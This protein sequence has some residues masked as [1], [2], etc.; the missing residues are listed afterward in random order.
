VSQAYFGYSSLTAMTMCP[1]VL[2]LV[3]RRLMHQLADLA[4]HDALTRVLNR[5][6]MEEALRRH[7]GQRGGT[8]L[9]W[10]VVDIDH[11]KRIN[12]QHG[13]G[14][15][16]E[17]LRALAQTLMRHVRAGDFVARTGGEEFV[18]GCSAADQDAVVRLGERL[19]SEVQALRVPVRTPAEALHCTV[20]IG[21]SAPFHELAGWEAALSQADAALYRAK[22]GG[23]NRV[24]GPTAGR[25]AAGAETLA[26]MAGA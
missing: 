6:G 7:F 14:T 5:N 19:R 22:A 23:R 3:F 26:E 12:D 10:L 8:A 24:E 15:G 20:S 16:D 2:W 9:A 11:F 18:I 25:G 4:T 1:L 21:R 13:H 17:V